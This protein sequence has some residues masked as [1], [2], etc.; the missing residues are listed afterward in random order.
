MVRCFVAVALLAVTW[1][2][3]GASNGYAAPCLIVVS[4]ETSSLALISRAFA[5]QQNSA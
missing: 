1:L 4:P 5:C 2:L 3:S